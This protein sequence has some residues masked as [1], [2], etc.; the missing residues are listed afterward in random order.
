MSKTKVKAF[1]IEDHAPDNPLMLQ[2]WMDC[3]HWA[4]G[5]EKILDSFSADTGCRYHAPATPLDKMIDDATGHGK[6][7]IEKFIPWFNENIW[8]PS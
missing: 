8:G 7:F 5:D 2:A 6:D 1:D 3:L 4:I